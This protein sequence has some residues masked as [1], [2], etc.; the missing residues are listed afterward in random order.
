MD[1]NSISVNSNGSLLAVCPKSASTNIK[2]YGTPNGLSAIK[3]KREPAS[4][5]QPQKWTPNKSSTPRTPPSSTVTA[6]SPPLAIVTSKT[7]E[8][9]KTGFS[10]KSSKVAKRKP[11]PEP[12]SPPKPKIVRI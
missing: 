2:I 12:I 7:P 8:K 6:S 1:T 5:P 3:N 4:V 11:S 9:E 10:T